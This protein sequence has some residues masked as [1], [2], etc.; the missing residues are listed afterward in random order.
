MINIFIADDQP[1]LRLGL[2]CLLSN[3]TDINVTGE[4][5]N[6][7]EMFELLQKH[8]LDLLVISVSLATRNGYGVLQ[9]VRNI[10]PELPVLV[11]SKYSEPRY[12][13]QPLKLG[14]RGYLDKIA[15]PKELIKAIRCISRGGTYINE[16]CAGALAFLNQTKNNTPQHETLSKREFQILCLIASNK[17]SKAISENLCISQKTVSTHKKRILQKLNLSSTGELIRYTIDNSL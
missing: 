13:L 12:A 5:N 11:L 15:I 9:Q 6:S 4:A 17:T 1:I 7:K 16:A 3:E 14:A 10:Y 8:T 2:T